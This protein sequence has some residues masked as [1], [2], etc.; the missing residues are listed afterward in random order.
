MKTI[1]FV[2]TDRKQ[3]AVT[4][5][6]NVNDHFRLKGISTKGNWKMG[7]KA[8]V[9]LT[10]YIA[11]FIL[12]LTAPMSGWLIFP[13]AALMGVAMA[14]VG[15][16]V[17]HDAAHGSFSTKSWVNKLVTHSIYMLGG[18]AFTWK[19][20]HNILHHTY[21]NIDGFD[22]DI[23]N[24]LVFRMSK[25]SPLKKIHRFQHLYALAFYSLMTL[26]R[27]VKDFT[28]LIKYNR[29]G[30][31]RQQGASPRAEMIRLIITK[32]LYLI[33][34]I[35]LPLIFSGFSWW[36]I[37]L[38]FL[39]MHLSAGLI[40]STVFQMAHIVEE[41]DQPVPSKEGVI[42]NDWTIHEL[43][44]TANF[45]RRS[46]WFGWGIGGLNYQIEHHLFPSICHIHYR[47]LSPIVERTAKEFGLR[48]NENPTF[49]NAIGSHFR[50]LRALGK[51]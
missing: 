18:S 40:M 39:V 12:L 3:F 14:G 20:Q 16:S 22:E 8:I 10:L 36:L 24:K 45:A 6:K 38:G 32:A 7:L 34:L 42:E 26:S 9:M 19:V 15:M 41:A 51:A 5:R 23:D 44:T 50:L 4:L 27:M 11:P 46:R 33:V 47:D 49:F 28:Q 37:L 35:G 25:V 17:M 1:K 30:I 2:N 29:A 21:T 13:I 48:Y 31:T 43:E